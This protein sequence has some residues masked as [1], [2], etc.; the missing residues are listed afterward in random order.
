ML[1]FGPWLMSPLPH[2]VE[3]FQFFLAPGDH[4][5]SLM[6]CLAGPASETNVSSVSSFG[7]TT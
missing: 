4:A 7:L 5:R 3:T 6:E 1:G 2:E